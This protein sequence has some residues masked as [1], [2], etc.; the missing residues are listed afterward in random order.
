MSYSVK[1]TKK[2]TV[3]NNVDNIQTIPT[4]VPF[5]Y[6]NDD[7]SE[8]NSSTTTVTK[9]IVDTAG[10]EVDIQ[11]DPELAMQIEKEKRENGQI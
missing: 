1:E 11:S 4:A 2:T 5:G 8:K 10:K 7:V 9:K 6:G 3:S